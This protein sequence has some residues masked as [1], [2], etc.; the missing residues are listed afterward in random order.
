MCAVGFTEVITI[1]GVFTKCV[2]SEPSSKR[3]RS[4]SLHLPCTCW[5]SIQSAISGTCTSFCEN[6]GVTVF[7]RLTVVCI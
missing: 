5:N 1:P 4:G 3:A 7:A 2:S 6:L